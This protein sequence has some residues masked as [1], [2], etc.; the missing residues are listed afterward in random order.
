MKQKEELKSKLEDL[1]GDSKNSSWLTK[2]TPQLY[3]ECIDYL[4]TFTNITVSSK[5]DNMYSVFSTEYRSMLMYGE[6]HPNMENHELSYF[7]VKSLRYF[8]G[9][10]SNNFDDMSEHRLHH[11]IVFR[12][13]REIKCII[14]NPP[15]FNST[16][17]HSNL[18]SLYENHAITEIIQN[19]YEPLYVSVTSGDDLDWLCSIEHNFPTSKS[20]IDKVINN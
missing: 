14:E 15:R 6:S 16:N 7:K 12:R 4:K 8:V 5:L 19:V 9:W 2:V 13:N 18:S 10:L 17:I 3:K 20:G 11:Y 1:K